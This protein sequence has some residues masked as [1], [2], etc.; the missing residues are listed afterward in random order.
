ML[1]EGFW[2][3]SVFL[4]AL[5]LPAS[6]AFADDSLFHTRTLSC[7][8]STPSVVRMW[9][10]HVKF[11]F[12]SSRPSGHARVHLRLQ[13]NSEVAYDV[14]G[15]ALRI[16]KSLAP[17]NDGRSISYGGVDCTLIHR[18]ITAIQNC[19]GNAGARTCEVGV[20][21]AGRPRAYLVSLSITPVAAE[22]AG[23]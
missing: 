12:L 21:L 20:D 7:V 19:S 18:S 8:A 16:D 4:L 9:V 10:D 13:D 23:R 11:V 1:P 15:E 14:S 22:S 5:I 17:N 3:R 2:S 6:R